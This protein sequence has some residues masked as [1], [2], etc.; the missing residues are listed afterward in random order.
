MHF[1]I[2]VGTVWRM[3]IDDERVPRGDWRD[4]RLWRYVAGLV[5][6]IL[7]VRERSLYSIRSLILSQ[8]REARR[9][10]I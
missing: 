7:Y 2:L 8:W 5:V 10:V 1:V 3:A 9:G 6:K 4:T